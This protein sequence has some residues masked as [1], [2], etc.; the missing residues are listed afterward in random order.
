M[1]LS[2]ADNFKKE[3]YAIDNKRMDYLLTDYCH[4][5]VFSQEKNHPNLNLIKTLNMT[6]FEVVLIYSR[7]RQE[8]IAMI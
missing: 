6:Q 7:T 1:N 2:R 5:V 4:I 3:I 8:G